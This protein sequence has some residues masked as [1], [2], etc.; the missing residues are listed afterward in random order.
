MSYFERQNP[1]YPQHDRQQS[2]DP[3]QA[4]PRSVASPTSQQPE[5][6]P[7]FS[8]QFEDSTTIYSTPRP[9]ALLFIAAAARQFVRP[10][11]SRFQLA[12]PITEVNRA[13]DNLV[14]SGRM[15]SGMPAMHN[16]RDS[17]PMS[18]PF[19]RQY[20][21]DYDPRMSSLSPHPASDYDGVRSSSSH[22]STSV[23]G[24]LAGQR[25][26]RVPN[27][28]DQIMQNKRRAAAQRERELRNYH[29]EQQYSRGPKPDRSA[30]PNG[31]NEEERRELLARQHRALYGND[32]SLYMQ[33]DTSSPRPVSQDARVLA[34]QSAG[35]QGSSSMN[36]D[37]Y[38][39][40]G[41]SSA[42]GLPTQAGAQSRQD[43]GSTIS[44]GPK[45]N[46]YAMYSTQ[47]V[48][49]QPG[50]SSSTGN[51]PAPQDQS[52]PPNS[53]GGVGP[54]GTRPVSGTISG[55]RNTP[56]QPSPLGYGQAQGERSQS[57]ASNPSM[58]NADKSVGLG[59][60]GNSGPWG[61]NKVQTSVWG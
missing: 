45:N 4:T 13:S 1:R 60:S 58:G 32:S 57:A 20:P 26:P 36:Y 30:S 21:P 51:T 50:A 33:S 41:P 29:Q 34:A 37:S 9:R 31:M 7:A 28:A 12:D 53:A 17:A 56:P 5:P 40:Q 49:S 59:W 42:E 15:A 38:G 43:E 55:K 16:R 6:S 14:R 11:Q 22:S 2:W 10:A 47:Q 35:G 23:P 52:L 44:P 39:M 24:Y 27:E 25:F 61:P 46:A 54:I 48:A 19:N 3:A 8:S 18:A